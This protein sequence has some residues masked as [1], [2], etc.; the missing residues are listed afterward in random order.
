VT[1]GESV[2]VAR[3]RYCGKEFDVRQF[4]VVLM[5]SRKAYHSTECALLDADGQLAPRSHD[6]G[7]RAG[8]P[9]ERR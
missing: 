9:V 8:T 5:G 1:S 4:Q 2:S 7:I 6:R 3:C